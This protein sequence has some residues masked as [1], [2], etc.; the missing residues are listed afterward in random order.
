[1]GAPSEHA[2]GQ[3]ARSGFSLV[4]RHDEAGCGLGMPQR[5]E[6]SAFLFSGRARA[7]RDTRPL[8]AR[9]RAAFIRA[10]QAAGPCSQRHRSSYAR[11]PFSFSRINRGKR[12]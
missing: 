6:T 7:A 11:E 12:S 3:R 5:A 2:G 10:A 4:N 9:R 8:P 1:M